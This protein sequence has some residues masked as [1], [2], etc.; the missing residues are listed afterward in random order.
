MFWRYEQNVV[1]M[2]ERWSILS[3][4]DNSFEIRRVKAIDFEFILNNFWKFNHFTLFPVTSI[5]DFGST[6]SIKFSIPLASAW[7]EKDKLFTFIFTFRFIPSSRNC[8]L[9][10]SSKFPTVPAT[11]YP[12]IIIVFLGSSH[13]SL[14]TCNENP[15]WSIPGVANRTIGLVDLIKDFSKGWMCLNSNKLL[16]L[17]LTK[18]TESESSTWYSH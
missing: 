6:F 4:D 7:A 12:G 16:I 3:F 5:T 17:I 11:Q 15:P 2:E 9:P 13:H 14:K 10:L 18:E 8:L 1:S